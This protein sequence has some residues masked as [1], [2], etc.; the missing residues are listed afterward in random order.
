MHGPIALNSTLRALVW[1]LLLPVATVFVSP[2][3]ASAAEFHAY[4]GAVG[5]KSRND[6]VPLTLSEPSTVRATLKWPK[7]KARLTLVLKPAGS[8]AVVKLR[9]KKRPKGFS[10]HAQPGNWWILVRAAKGGSVYKLNVSIEPVDS[11]IPPPP[12]EPC[13]GVSVAPGDDIQ[14]MMAAHPGGTT[15]CFASGR[16]QLDEPIFPQSY[17]RLIAETGAVL[18]GGNTVVG[19]VYGTGGE[20]GQKSV[21]VRGFI[22]QNFA[23]SLT[24]PSKSAAIKAGWSWTIEWNE[25]RYNRSEGIRANRGVV[26]RNNFVHHNGKYGVV[27]CFADEMV[28]EGNEIAYN[29]TGDHSFGDAGASKICK[30]ANVV[31]R[32]NYVHH[33]NGHGLWA[34]TDNI[35]FLYENN[36]VTQNVGI[37]ILH[38]TSYDAI[39]RDNVVRYNAESARN[40]SVGYGSNILI[41]VSQD[42][43]IYGNTVEA[44]TNGIG[45]Y[46]IAR[47]SGA[48]GEWKLQNVF[49]HDNVVKMKGTAETGLGG[50]P[51][52][53]SP[54]AKNR[55]SKNSYYITEPSGTFWYWKSSRSWSE[56]RAE[57]QDL[58]GSVSVWSG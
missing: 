47:G 36:L 51:E 21:T 11:W 48:Y 26:V 7:R 56:W 14:D 16:Y 31:L 2:Q 28:W 38:E 44:D 29:N 53:F 12:S 35:N 27:G 22:V 34:D 1:A 40:K 54:Q 18:D 13:E 10:Y 6:F 43:E 32:G 49:V 42:V 5:A 57:D 37:G 50:R 52:A 55:F 3:D 9:G 39:I 15:Y 33:N 46:D 4:S 17:D 20:T 23:S 58:N 45:L 24:D 8:K 19:A 30:S 41:Y 25:I